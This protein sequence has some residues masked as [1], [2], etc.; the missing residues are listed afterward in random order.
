MYDYIDRK[1]YNNKTSGERGVSGG[2]GGGWE[3]SWLHNTLA[4]V[5][6]LG[7]AVRL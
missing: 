6:Q 2:G 4:G 1:C 3:G 5:S 7:L